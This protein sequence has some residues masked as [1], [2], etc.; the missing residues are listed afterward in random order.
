MGNVPSTRIQKALFI[1]KKNI[2]ENCLFG[3]DINP[4]S[5]NICRLRLWIELL[6]NSY[7]DES[8][9]LVTLPNIDINIKVGDSLLHKFDLDFSFDMRKNDYKEYL[10]LVKE[11][12]STNNK[13]TK[14]D[15]FEKINKIKDSFDDTATS[16]E[17]KR[18]NKLQNELFNAQQIQ[19]FGDEKEEGKRYEEVSRQ[20]SDAKKDFKKA[21]QNPMFKKGLEWRMEFPE[22]LDED[23]EFIGFDLIIGNP[24]YIYSNNNSFNESQKNY[25]L[26][27]YPLNKYQANTFGLFIE[28]GFLLLRKGGTLSFIIPNSLLTIN[29]Y[30]EMRS[31]LTQE[32]GNLYILNSK[33]KIFDEASIDVCIISADKREANK[34]I[35][36]EL[37]NGDWKIVSETTPSEMASFE[38][39][40]DSFK[41]LSTIERDSKPFEENYGN[42]RAGL[43]AYERGKGKPTQPLDKEEFNIFKNKREFFSHERV[44][45]NYRKFLVGTDLKRYELKWSGKYI[46]YGKNLAAP[47][48][49]AIFEGDRIV[50]GRIPV[51]NSYAFRATLTADEFVHEQSINSLCNLRANPFFLIGVLNSKVVS[52][53]ALQK[54]DFLQRKTFPQIR[55]TQIKQ[56]PIPD[57]T[58]DQQN[59]LAELVKQLMDEMKED[60][61]HEDLIST[62]NTQID[63]AVMELFGLTEDE[64][65][66]VREFEV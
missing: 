32:C 54:F 31:F 8:G 40:N 17:L 42:V 4:N 25:F 38:V 7:Y 14:A 49:P 43:E 28:L 37:E 52:Y 46:K 11:Y 39:I 3:V 13:H 48:N 58:D 47:R 19:L 5:A 9:E 56:F 45:E 55:L 26:K 41:I 33:D 18:L 60:P 35:L 57:G 21:M 61:R 23:G 30:Q 1:Q 29:Q 20:L 51:K 50:L 64:K 62:L 10:Q 63:E 22:I 65:Q 53:Y 12:K 27:T 59:S 66:S 16:P 24:P 15:I 34:I 44:D 2:I 6:K 36:A